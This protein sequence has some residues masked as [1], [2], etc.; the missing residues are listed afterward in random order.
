MWVTIGETLGVKSKQIH[1]FFHNTW[2]KRFYDDLN[3]YKDKLM[4]L[5]QREATRSTG[6]THEIV[7]HVIAQFQQ[8]NPR[9]RVHV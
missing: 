7:N 6:S 8:E 1:D 5:L 9:A 4:H 3:Q 2:V